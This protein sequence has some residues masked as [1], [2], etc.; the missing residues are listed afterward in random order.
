MAKSTSKKFTDTKTFQAVCTK[1]DFNGTRRASQD[2]AETDAASHTSKP[3]KT[4]HVVKII[5]TV[6][7]VKA[8]SNK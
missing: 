7:T 5:T 2:E 6:T 8:F 3:G 1:G 4:N